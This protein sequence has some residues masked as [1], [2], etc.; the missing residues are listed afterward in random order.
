MK[1]I[2]CF[3]LLIWFLGWF[4][5]GGFS[6][7]HTEYNLTATV[8]SCSNGI[9]TVCDYNGNE[10]EYCGQAVPGREV[11]LIMDDNATPHKLTDD[12]IKGVK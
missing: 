10:W 5:S 9:V 4:L 3:N 2:I 12:I 8:A 6:A 11:V 1:K 7:T